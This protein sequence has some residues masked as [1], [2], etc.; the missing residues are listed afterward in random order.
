MRAVTSNRQTV[1][2]WLGEQEHPVTLG[3]QEIA[4]ANK[5]PVSQV[6]R[7]LRKL[8]RSGWSIEKEKK[9]HKWVI[10]PEVLLQTEE[11]ESGEESG[12]EVQIDSSSASNPIYVEGKL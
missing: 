2:N 7:I 12:E 3:S 8:A 1:E 4:K 9:G 6:H 10:E 11:N 5:I